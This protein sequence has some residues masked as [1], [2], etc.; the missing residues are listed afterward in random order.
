MAY[1]PLLPFFLGVPWPE[2]KERINTNNSFMAGI[3]SKK[4]TIMIKLSAI[5]S[6]DG[7]DPRKSAAKI[8][9][10]ITIYI[11]AMEATITIYEN[12]LSQ[13]EARLSERYRKIV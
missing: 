13:I 2:I 5:T 4:I 12:I 1:F 3:S 8:A 9:E 10:K 11:I 7:V 6:I